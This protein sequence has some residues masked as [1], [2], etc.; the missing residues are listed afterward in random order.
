MPSA[1]LDQRAG[2]LELLA[3]LAHERLTANAFEDALEA[4]AEATQPL[5]DDSPWAANVR[6][7][8]R[9]HRFARALPEPLVA[10]AAKTHSLAQAKWAEA[11]QA[12]DFAAFQPLLTQVLD[13]ARERA[14]CLRSQLAN[15]GEAGAQWNEDWDALADAYE[16]GIRAADLEPLFAALTP[17]L[18]DLVASVAD[19][20]APTGAA[21]RDHRIAIDAQER[22]VRHVAA[23]LGFD[24]ERGRMDRSTHPFC[25]GTHPD[26]VR[27]TTRFLENDI[28]DG[29]GSTMHETG[30]ALYELGLPAAFAGTPAG[31]AASLGLHESQ[32]RLWEN[33]VGRSRAFWRWARPEADRI[34]GH[35]ALAGFDAEDVF[36]AAN[37]VSPSLIRVEAD[38]VTYDLHVALR[39][40]LERALI[41]GTLDVADLPTA[42]NDGM[43]ARLGI[44]VPDD[45]RGCLQDVHWSCG[46]IGY[47]PT[48][49]LGNIWAAELAQRARG[50]LHD[51]DEQ[52]ARGEFSPLRAWLN[53]KVHRHGTTLRAEDRMRT[54]L[55]RDAGPDAMLAHLEERITATYH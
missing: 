9:R 24:A 13:V 51:L 1:G 22:F 40:E 43:K 11:R 41:R 25:S 12:S 8:R 31:Q 37:V 15:P 28:L 6:E 45:A 52:F 46:L 47:F 42:W 20:P 34:L 10:R 16:P 14:R 32:S 17:R 19:C 49:T 2:Q 3:R 38:E 21:M 33:H 18:T 35:D 53:E 55:G 54:I 29:L 23:S 4:A 50:D 5:P 7:L 26:D 48:Y 36:R 44:E 30:H 27:V 39:F